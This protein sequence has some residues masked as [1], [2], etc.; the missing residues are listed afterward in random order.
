MTQAL[1]EVRDL[2]RD[3]VLPRRHLF[4]P[5]PRVRAL[6]GVGFRIEAGHSFG[7]VGESAWRAPS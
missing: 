2:V 4:V 5:P 6:D 1:L 7:I 3:Y